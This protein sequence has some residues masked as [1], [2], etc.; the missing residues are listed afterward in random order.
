MKTE[1]ELR[2][3][4]SEMTQEEK[5]AQTTQ[6]I[7]NYYQK[8][9]TEVTGPMGQLGIKSESMKDLGSV[10]GT[11]FAE[12]VIA[13]QKKYL[14]ENRLH[15]P[16]LFMTDVIHG[17]RTIYPIPLG[18]GA[19]FDPA[20]VEECSAM[21]AAEAS[22]NGIQ[23][24]FAPMA[25]YVRDARWGR[26][27]ESFGEDP[28]LNSTLCAAETVGFQGR[29]GDVSKPDRIAACVKHVAAYGGAE[30]GRDYNSVEISERL[31]REY[32]FPAYKACIDAGAKALMPSFNSLNGIPSTANSWLMKEV[33]RGE[34]GFDGVAISD[35]GA[36]MELVRHGVAA[37]RKEAARLAGENECDIEMMSSA[38]YNHL[39]ELVAEG[40][41]RQETLDRMV[42]RILRLKNDLGLFDDP[43]HG[44]SP[45][46]AKAL[47]LCE[48]HR[49]LALRAAEESA[50]LLKNDGVLPFSTEV[51]KIALIGPYASEH[52]IIGQWKARGL[53]EES[54]SVEEGVRRLLPDTE[55]LTATGC[56]FLWDDLSEE[57]F[58]EAVETA[59]G[60]D[61]VILCLGEPDR[62]S[63]EGKCRTDLRLPGAQEKLAKAVSTVNK[64]TA[65]LL[66]AGRPLVLTEVEK[67]VPA[68]LEMWFPGNEGGN[69]AAH[70]LF[71][72]ACP[73][74]KLPMSFPKA[75]GQVPLYYNRPSTGRPKKKPE[76]VYE[77]FTSN[78]IDCG[79]LALYPFGYGLSYAS[80]VYSS[81]T[82]DKTSLDPDGELTV[83]V[84]VKNEGSVEGKETVQLYLRD[85]VA[86]TVRPTQSLIAFEKVTLAPGEERDVV[87]K[88]TEPMLR[89]YD[90]HCVFRSEAGEFQIS[91][92]CA[93]RLILTKTFT[94][95]EGRS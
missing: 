89:F 76:G 81:L 51:K 4:L 30:S 34:W 70:L 57:G 11:A 20:L 72:K 15:I 54:V 16:M 78:Y 24:T 52:A 7:I 50:V 48:A 1:A 74:G 18:L 41:I 32:Y 3:L 42:L 62:Y 55:I 68:I 8:T 53:A 65:L 66:F 95:T 83:T 67:T 46:K 31:L 58:A 45:E 90:F 2:H 61:A 17:Y 44:A 88:I 13:I 38:Y 60:A 25:D 63:G 94:L 9:G 80:F 75:T 29:D 93:D 33:V 10:L 27:M 71:G 59:K 23:L 28:L 43:F 35:W 79:N 12:D 37:D 77:D 92:G 5:I 73:C 86:S 64:N 85:L 40:I 82:L 56:S 14:A 84:R 39:A 22:A 19:S 49:A 26:V 87:F 69:A 36:V 21:A 47:S 6:V 91:T